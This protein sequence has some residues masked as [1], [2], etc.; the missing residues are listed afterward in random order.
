MK[1]KILFYIIFFFTVILYAQSNEDCWTLI[2]SGID[3]YNGQYNNNEFPGYH[4]PETTDLEEITGGFLTTGQYNKQTFDSN[5]NNIYTNL[6][7][8]DGSYLT[9]HDYNGNLQWIVYT[10]KNINSYRDVMFGSV[11]DSVGN[12]YVIGHSINGTFFDSEG[13]EIIFNNSND[14]L[15]GGFIVKLDEDGKILWH[16]IINNVYSKKINIDEEDNILLSGDVNVYNNGTFDFYLNGVITD[17]L[18]NFEI[19]GNNSNY[20][21]RGI[22]KI[23]PEGDL[24]WYTS[25]KTSGPNSEFLIDIGSDNNNNIYVTGY[26]SSNAEIYSAGETD[27]PDIISWTGNPAKTFLIKFD[28]QGQFLWK[29]KSLL[30]DPEINGVQAWSTFVDEQGNS[31]IT[32][33]N[34]RWRGNF[35]QIFENTDGSTTSENVG[36][37]FV[38]KVNTYGVCE[39]IKGAA[40]SYSGTGYKVIKSND[41]IIVV[42]TV[43][44]F[45]VLSEEV[46]FL[47]SDGNNIQA[48]FYPNDYFFAIYDTDGNV[49]RVVSNGIN[50]QRYFYSDRI[51]GFF[52]DSNDN[53]YIS[54]NL[55][56]YTNGPQNYENFG[57]VINAQSLNG[58]EGT[59]TKFREE[60][61]I[62]IG[63]IINQ[64]IAPLTLC[65]NESIGTDSDGLVKIDLTEHED[66]FL[67][68][69]SI[70]D[71]QFNYYTDSSYINQIVD[72]SGY[73]N[74]NQ[75]ETIYI[76][77]IHSSNPSKSGQTSFVIEVFELPT[78]TPIVELTQCDDNTDGI[79]LFNLEEVIGEITTNAINETIT[80]HETLTDATLGNS[81][82][83]NTTNY[84]NATPSTDTVWARIVNGNDCIRTSQVNLIISTTEIPLTFTR[85]FYEC[86]DDIAGTITDGISSFD[87]STVTTEIEA[88]F[89]VGQQLVITYYRNL[90]DALSEKNSITDITDYRN[91]GYPNT[92]NIYIR[93]DS[94]LDNDCLGLGA[95]IN[96]YVEPIP[97]ANPVTIARQCDDDFDGLYPFDTSQI[98]QTVLNGQTGMIVSY[99]DE[100]GNP[101][102][103]PLP[104]PFL[105]ASQTI[106]IN[107]TDSNSKD[108][109]GACSAATTL[110]FIVDKK[111]I[112][113]PV[114]D[115]ITCDDDLD[116][117][118]EFDTSNI[119]QTLLNGQTGMVVSYVDALGTAL[120]SPLPNPFTSASQT[121]TAKVENV[122]NGNCFAETPINFIVRPKPQFELDSDGVVCLNLPPV[123]FSIQNPNEANY[124]YS[125]TNEQGQEISNL[126][127][128]GINKDGIYT[129]VATSIY[130]CTS[131]PEKINITAYSIASITSE[132]IEITDDSDNN[133]IEIFTSNLGIGNYEFAIQ[134]EGESIG[135]YQDEPIFENIASGIYRVFVNDKNNCGEVNIDVS[136]IGYP[137]FFTPNNDGYNDYWNVIG[138]N[139]QFYANSLIYIFDRFGKIVAK[140][141]PKTEGWNGFYNG[142][143]LPATDYWFSVE[144][145]DSLGNTQIRKGHFSLIR[146]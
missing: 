59:I 144:L 8:K 34:D 74:T 83:S 100:L 116:G 136:V 16:I 135:F 51:S 47:S 5:D 124:T 101:L 120:S 108:K 61:G 85:D 130:G 72:P 117:V 91:V 86:D 139:E 63:N 45:N 125:W 133:I 92:Q 20:V 82:I 58:R 70:T 112:A 18:S 42:G 95:H 4:D 134:K 31:Y 94:L 96:L 131:F 29:V 32:G 103:S 122:L 43:R 7:N 143:S 33:S 65:D 111:P 55:G 67:N 140:V 22:L 21:N 50:D 81:P 66:S 56:F 73:E 104:N 123:E 2:N 110:E 25:I 48:S 15:F 53:Y 105:T 17:N 121:I 39:W 6:E 11:E 109:N 97:I 46:E 52:K 99:T 146:R 28:E 119:E 60:C 27:N 38:A 107:V 54:R 62:I 19:M 115:F 13:T 87:F 98:E 75:I 127:T 40:H 93:V 49:N 1:N 10:E 71:Y 128:A 113:N 145:N 132:Q 23:N 137:K 64:N 3:I 138:V 141:D 36:T 129:V 84:L 12:I 76:D 41:E 142:E 118:I 89:P 68:S 9:K 35:D 44:G 114:T 88:L 77:V 102:S 79:S 126:P 57:H 24:L 69:D 14:S 106:S 26:C 90:A 30:D 80:F 78:V 37:F